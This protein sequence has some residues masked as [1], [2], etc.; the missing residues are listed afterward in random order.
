M[1]QTVTCQ[2]QVLGQALLHEY[3]AHILSP[4]YNWKLQ[5]MP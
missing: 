3:S 4:R 5:C 1:G 2:V